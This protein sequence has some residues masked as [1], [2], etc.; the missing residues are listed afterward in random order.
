MTLDAADR[1]AI[2]ELLGL[3]G[4]LIDERRWSELDQVFTPDAVYDATS[5]GQGVTTSLATLIEHWTS[6]MTMHPLAHHATNIV[7]TEDSDGTVRVLSKGLGVGRKG[8]V[9]SVTYRDIAV[10]SPD[11]WRLSHRTASLRR[12]E[13]W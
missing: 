3:Y 4:H 8:R 10:R 5:F 7:V 9:G 11:G 1:I 2:H 12:S 6:D 13:D